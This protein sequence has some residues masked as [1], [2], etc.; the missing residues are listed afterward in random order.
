MS[1]FAAL[2]AV[3]VV[4]LGATALAQS[5]P[6]LGTWKLNLGK[7]KF[8]P[9]LPP[10]SETRV[11][12]AWETDGIKFTGTRVLADG[13]R[14][15]VGFSAHYDGKDYKVTGNPDLDTIGIMRV[16]ANTTEATY[17]KGGKVIGTLTLVVSKDGKMLNAT[18]TLMNANG[19]TVSRVTV[20]DK[21]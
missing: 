11:F 9:E 16:D 4:V 5:D 19:Q 10:M 15:S 7:S 14:F 3:S 13:T 18:A 20:F 17:K 12:E 21:Q 1:L 8:E 6:N 2:A